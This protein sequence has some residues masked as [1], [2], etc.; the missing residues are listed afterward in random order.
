MTLSSI[1]DL[2][3]NTRVL[4]SVADP[5]AKVSDHVPV[6]SNIS[7]PA[8]PNATLRLPTWIYEHPQYRT[9]LEAN[10]NKHIANNP[11]VS[12]MDDD[13]RHYLVKQTIVITAKQF[14]C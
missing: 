7:R 6:H 13:A 14:L 10:Y 9:L 5:K 1:R 4:W 8:D 2:V 11:A 3:V 12:K